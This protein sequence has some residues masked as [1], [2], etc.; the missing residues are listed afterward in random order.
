MAATTVLVALYCTLPL[1]RLAKVPVGVS[2][3]V[4]LLILLGLA[5]WQVRAITR[6]AHPVV[7]AVQ[8]LAITAPLFLLL[9][10]LSYCQPGLLQQLTVGSG[11]G[12]L[13]RLDQSARRPPPS[14]LHTLVRATMLHQHPP[15]PVG[16]DDD[17][18][19]VSDLHARRP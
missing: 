14:R 2:L 5:T 16:E 3:T 9:F 11:Q 12:V 4:A 15:N 6:A 8:A 17:R 18:N 19:F 7:R 10:A 13:P 1:D